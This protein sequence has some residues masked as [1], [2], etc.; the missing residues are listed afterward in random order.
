[1]EYS[2]LYAE[3]I[4]ALCAEHKISINQLAI[5]SG[6]PQSTLDNIM[7][8]LTKNPR[9]LTLHK[10]ANAL[11]MTPAEFLDFPELNDCFFEDEMP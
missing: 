4:R 2:K 11:G 1:M 3:R 10:I 6:V 8:G 9:I 5:M 7:R